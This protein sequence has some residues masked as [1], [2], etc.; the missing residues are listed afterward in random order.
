MKKKITFLFLF[1][2]LGTTAVWA[3]YPFYIRGFPE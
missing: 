1:P 2:A 3:Q